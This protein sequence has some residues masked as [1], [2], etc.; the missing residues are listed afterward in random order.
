M[1]SK[2]FLEYAILKSLLC[3]L[4]NALLT[5]CSSTINSVVQILSVNRSIFFRCLFPRRVIHPFFSILIII[6][7][8]LHDLEY[9]YTLNRIVE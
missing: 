9:V 4:T 5:D 6:D 1:D 8:T 7:I 2:N 3:N